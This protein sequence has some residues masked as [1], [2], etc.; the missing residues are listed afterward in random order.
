M[1]QTTACRGWALPHLAYCMFSDAASAAA[2]RC[3]ISAA[4]LV[5]ELSPLPTEE[6]PAQSSSA[7]SRGRQ[8]AYLRA[9]TGASHPANH[10]ARLAAARGVRDAPSV[11]LLAGA[12]PFQPMDSILRPA[13][14]LRSEP[15][16]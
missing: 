5:Y 3:A 12:P 6:S 7:P 16:D 10:V 13:E 15:R 11:D 8:T 4:L 2:L 14:A 9:L 1:F